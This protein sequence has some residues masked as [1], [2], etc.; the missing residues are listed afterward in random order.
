MRWSFQVNLSSC[1]NKNQQSTHPADRWYRKTAISGWGRGTRMLTELSW[2]KNQLL[3]KELTC[4]S[5]MTSQPPARRFASLWCWWCRGLCCLERNH[6]IWS[7][8]HT[9]K[10]FFL[11]C[12]FLRRDGVCTRSYRADQQRVQFHQRAE[13]GL[14]VSTASSASTQPAGWISEL[15]PVVRAPL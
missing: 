7:G 2:G 4:F 10:S 9:K 12:C 3:K 8:P 6:R 13:G 11:K 15:Q 14:A 1:G 5:L